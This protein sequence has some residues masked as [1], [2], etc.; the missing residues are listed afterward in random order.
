MVVAV[1]LIKR[2]AVSNDYLLT[3]NIA[4]VV[5]RPEI[6]NNTPA[7]IPV[8]TVRTQPNVS[9]LPTAVEVHLLIRLPRHPRKPLLLNCHECIILNAASNPESGSLNYVYDNNG[10]LVRKLDARGVYTHFSYDSLNRVVRKWYNDSASSG[11]NGPLPTGVG[12][13]NEVLYR[14]DTG[15]KAKGQ[16]VSVAS[17]NYRTNIENR[18]ELGRPRRS[19]QWELTDMKFYWDV[20]YTYQ[21]SGAVESQTYPFPASR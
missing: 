11:T 17:G 7:A 10:N 20:S 6:V 8:N 14:Y 15:V 5:R 18:D 1:C 21:R 3:L 4:V 9:H 19:R 12:V 16:L 2:T 13:T